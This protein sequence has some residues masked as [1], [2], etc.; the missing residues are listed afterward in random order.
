MHIVYRRLYCLLLRCHPASFRNQFAHEMVL[1]FEEVLDTYG[2]VSLFLDA[3]R[4]LARQWSACILSGAIHPIDTPQPS[5][6][7]GSYLMVR[8]EKLRPLELG[9]G[10]FASTALIGLCLFG[11]TAS[12]GHVA[13]LSVV[14][15]ASAT[16]G[17]NVA[18]GS[19]EQTLA[20]QPKPE[21]LLFHPSGPPL[22]Y[23]VATIKPLDPETA[24]SVVRLPPGTARSTSLS[25]LTIRR[26][27]MNA[28]GAIYSAQIV[29]G[30]DWLDKDAYNI[31]GKIP[32]NLEA[33]FAGMTT[34]ER[35]ATN[36]NLQQFLLADRFH[37]KAHFETRVLPVYELVPTKTGLKI[38]KVPAP[39]DQK[40][41]DPQSQIHPGDPLR[42]GFS[43]STTNGSGLRV[44]NGR[45]IQMQLL[46]RVV[47]G[48]LGDRPIVDHS[49]FTGYFDVTD[50]TWAPLGDAGTAST[51]D[52]PP[53]TVALEQKLGLKVVPTKAPIEVL[54]IDSINRPT[55]D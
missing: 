32:G 12:P 5:L 52:A 36:R 38:T 26:Y 9:R 19:A 54:V 1:D 37:L 4:S 33:A 40:P 35:V 11:L 14:Y 41:G 43:M 30:P 2:L 47:G 17:Q 28:Y 44:L 55:P 13:N 42:S 6:L 16:P 50:L 23:E 29:G 20:A 3:A 7:M 48:D 15:A 8:D 18:Q 53:L 24:A 51:A 39:V 45:A 25:P 21:L 31:K 22:S 27:I 46:A 10:L 49:G 34:Q